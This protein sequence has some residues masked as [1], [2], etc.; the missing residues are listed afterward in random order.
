MPTRK[1]MKAVFTFTEII[2]KPFVQAKGA[3]L[4]ERNLIDIVLKNT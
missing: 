2:V 4:G 3:F 1:C